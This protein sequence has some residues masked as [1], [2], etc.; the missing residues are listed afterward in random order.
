MRSHFLF[1]AALLAGAMAVGAAAHAGPAS[2]PA[3]ASAAAPMTASAAAPTPPSTPAPTS[4]PA[5]T[6][7]GTPYVHRWSKNGQN[8]FTPPD[9]ADLARWQD[10]VTLQLYDKVHSPDQLAF[11]ANSVL[12]AYR[13]AGLIIRTNSLVAT[14]QRPAEHMVVA[15][16]QDKGLR[17]M[18]FAR[19]RLT[20]EGG[21][22]IVYSHR[23]YGIKPDDAAS[24]WFRAHDLP[25]EKAMMTWTDIPS[26]A[27]LRALPQ[28]P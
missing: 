15:V 8:E 28:S 23:V 21:E 22:A 26:V 27:A 1:D 24:A 7:A 25:M 18:V 4:A 12:L 13:K 16:L 10:M 3:A 20:P 9:Q 19:F 2:E 17:E 11:V 6:F 14:P 5:F